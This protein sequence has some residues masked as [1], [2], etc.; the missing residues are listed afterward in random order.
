M[1]CFSSIESI[2]QVPASQC[3][4]LD[5]SIDTNGPEIVIDKYKGVR[6]L[7]CSVHV[8]WDDSCPSRCT[9]ADDHQADAA[10]L[11]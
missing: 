5:T 8:K 10:V 11:L 2:L 6:Q 9:E 3:I 4:R 1:T 7:A